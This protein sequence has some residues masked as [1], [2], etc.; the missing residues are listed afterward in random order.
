MKKILLV[1]APSQRSEGGDFN[2][3]PSSILHA[4]SLS[5]NSMDDGQINESYAPNVFAPAT[6]EGNKTKKELTDIIEREKADTLLVSSTCESY[7]PG[8]QLA[9]AAKKIDPTITTVFGG[10]HF[11]DLFR[12]NI[13]KN[14]PHL[15]PFTAN[16]KTVDFVITGDAEYALKRFLEIHASSPD[17]ANTKAQ[18]QADTDLRNLPGNFQIIFEDGGAVRTLIS[19]GKKMDLNQLPYIRRDLVGKID[20]PFFFGDLENQGLSTSMMTHRGCKARCYYCSE[21]PG[22]NSR[23]VDHVSGEINRLVAQGYRSLFFDCGTFHDF[24]KLDDLLAILSVYNLKYGSLTRFDKLLDP[25][26]VQKLADTGFVHFLCGMEQYDNTV[27]RSINKNINVDAID[28]AIQ[29]LEGTPIKIGL[30]LLFGLPAETQETVTKTMQYCGEVVKTG[31]IDSVTLDLVSIHPGTPL[32]Y[33][34][35]PDV[36]RNIDFNGEPPNQGSPWNAFEEG[37]WFHPPNVTKQHAEFIVEQARKF[38][39]SQ[40]IYHVF[41]GG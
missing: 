21:S 22:Y 16:S 10:P 1:S 34:L 11:D 36:I 37:S 33:S 28:R 17:K 19:R 23:S 3:L 15:S 12:G 40:F 8:L 29:N 13:P 7:M 2:Y 35:S 30:T 39:P 6:Y 18:L 25:S 20:S 9:S 27:L 31:V 38:I 14:Y 5:L 26:H 41:K 32:F 4:V 24:P